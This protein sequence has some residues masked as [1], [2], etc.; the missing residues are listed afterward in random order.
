MKPPQHRSALPPLALDPNSRR[1][2]NAQLAESLREAIRAGRIAPG[3]PMPPTR[4]A[5]LQLGIGR[6]TVV[7][8]Y[9]DLVAEGLLEAR[10]RLG[11]FAAP[12]VAR[13]ST[14]EARSPRAVLRLAGQRVATNAPAQDWRLGQ[15][16]S[17]LLPLQVWR[18]ACREAG[19]HLPPPDYGDPKGLPSL[20]VA[21]A[22]WLRRHRGTD[23]DAQQIVVTQGTG[24]ALE[25][26]ARVLVRA[27]DLCAVESPGYPRAAAAF[28]AAGGT[29][30]HVPVD[31]QGMQV[32]SAFAGPAPTVL[33][34]TAAH[35]YPS[36][37]RLSGARR[38]ELAAL[39][40]RRGSLVIEN[41]YDHEFIY[42]GQNHA[43]L[44]GSL[45]AHTVL[46]STFAKAISPALRIGFIA[47]PHAVAATLAQAIERDRL[48]ASWP[49]Q[50]SLQW[51]LAAGELQRHLR[52]VRRH[53]ASQRGRLVQALKQRCPEVRFRGQEGGLHIALT[54]GEPTLDRRLA[55][56]LREL[57]IAFQTMREFGGDSDEVLLG[58][59][60]MSAH[61][62]EHAAELLAKAL[63]LL[64]GRKRGVGR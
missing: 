41:E 50:T 58:Y 23:H 13:T 6:N 39:V 36:G 52:R 26:L 5:A 2:L 24:A 59:G 55:R 44:A 19:R 46:V 49:V 29:V 8:A 11:T 10:G 57:G 53:H 47:A 60:H 31:S 34:L 15:S 20:R 21:I 32:G 35:Q 51:L 16:G 43:A 30:L 9:S 45:P 17:Q 3:R 28:E 18:A 38:A 12:Q 64:Q 54:M 62:I 7:D 22:A 56:R 27:G 4:E 37:V 40:I 1:P 14:T 33:H 25:L 48:H 63:S 42:E 61:E